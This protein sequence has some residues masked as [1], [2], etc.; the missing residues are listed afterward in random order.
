MGGPGASPGVYAGGQGSLPRGP[1]PGEP[2]GL[3]RCGQ[4]APGRQPRRQGDLLLALM[5]KDGGAVASPQL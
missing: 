2:T 5:E 4:A 1:D 3:A